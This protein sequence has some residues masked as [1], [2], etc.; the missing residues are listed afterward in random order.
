[1]AKSCDITASDRR[2]RT[3]LSVS[4]PCHVFVR[5]FRKIVSG[6][7]LLSGFCLESRL[8]IRIL[9]G[10]TRTSQSCPDFHFPYPPTSDIYRL[11]VST[12][13]YRLIYFDLYNYIGKLCEKFKK[14]KNIWSQTIERSQEFQFSDDSKFSQSLKH[15]WIFTSGCRLYDKIPKIFP[16]HFKIA[17][18]HNNHSP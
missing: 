2:R 12:G 5:I 4:C 14:S 10:R 7:Y 6:V 15:T 11:I 9:S 8:L 3:V 1:M 13:I 17:L 16:D 18:S